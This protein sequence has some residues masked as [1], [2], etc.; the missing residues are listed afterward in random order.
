MNRVVPWMCLKDGRETTTDPGISTGATAVARPRKAPQKGVRR[1]G[2]QGEASK[3]GGVQGEASK[4]H[5]PRRKEKASKGHRPRRQPKGGAAQEGPQGG[6]PPRR[7]QRGRQKDPPQRGHPPRT[8][9]DTHREAPSRRHLQG[10]THPAQG[11]PKGTPTAG[12]MRKRKCGRGNAE[13]GTP[14]QRVQSAEGPRT[15]KRP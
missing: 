4:G 7:E 6:H 10:D 11:C 8:K 5:P 2:V 15:A 1:K 9:E 14:P 12:G 3:E 13:E